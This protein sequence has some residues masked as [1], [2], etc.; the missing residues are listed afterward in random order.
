MQDHLGD[1]HDLLGPLLPRFDELGL[2]D[3]A[4]RLRAVLG[5]GEPAS[6]SAAQR[7]VPA[8]LSPADLMSLAEAA[9]ALGLRSASTV[10]ALVDTGR[11]EGFDAAAGPVVSRRS[12][13]SYLESP[14]LATQRRVEEQLWAV[15][16][17]SEPAED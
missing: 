14:S 13:A 15:L 5:Q 8:D 9:E 17:G 11:L 12:V 6:D 1:P 4:R 16:S 10:Q 3:I 2:T 7:E